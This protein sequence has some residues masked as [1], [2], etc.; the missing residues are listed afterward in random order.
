M[1]L[2]V[3]VLLAALVWQVHGIRQELIENNQRLRS[4][5]IALQTLERPA[6]EVAS[7]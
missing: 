7:D 1:S 3:V 5:R 6:R 4:L 2:L